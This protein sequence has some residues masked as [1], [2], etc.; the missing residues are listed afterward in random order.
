MINPCLN[1]NQQSQ[2]L[3]RWQGLVSHFTDDNVEIQTDCKWIPVLGRSKLE[4]ECQLKH[5]SYMLSFY[6][7]SFL[8]W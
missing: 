8:G 5:D 6:H 7:D 3:G 4:L 1:K 2:E